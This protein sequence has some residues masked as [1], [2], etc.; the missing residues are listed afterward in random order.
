MWESSNPALRNEDTFRQFYGRMAERADTATL[1]GVVNKTAILTGIAVVAG[2]GGYWA[3]GTVTAMPIVWLSCLASMAVCFGAYFLLRGNAAHARWLAPVYAVTEGVFLG[4]LTGGL[5]RALAGM[6]IAVTGGVAL[7]AFI[8]TASILVAMLALYSLRL[9]RPTQLL[10]SV[11]KVAT[12]GIMITYG[13][14]WVAWLLGVDLPLIGLSSAFGGGWQPLVG[15]GINVLI[16]GV[17]S[18]WLI[19][20]FKT[21]ED[22]VS[23][24]GPRVM[25]WYGGFVLLV[26][27][28]WVYYEAVKLVFRLAVLFNSRD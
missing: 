11:V 5:D 24:G 15:I 2:A 20:D 27:L 21:V 19:I 8:I 25:E 18:L 16:L 13:M 1:Q 9:L 4:A 6:Q 22:L 12:L 10:V 3:I 17:A 28:A 23:E 7:Q 26:S 14:S